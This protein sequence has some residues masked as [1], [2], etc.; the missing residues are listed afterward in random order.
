MIFFRHV[1]LK[2]NQLESYVFKSIDF[3]PAKLLIG[4]AKTTIR[5][6]GEDE[7]SACI[8]NF[9]IYDD[10]QNNGYG[11]DLLYNLEEYLIKKHDVHHIEF[12]SKTRQSE[13]NYPFFIKHN[14]HQTDN[15]L[16]YQFQDD[17]LDIYELY[18]YIKKFRF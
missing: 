16:N 9:N 17:G 18:H 8:H 5:K 15:V 4:N 10:Y 7:L 1:L 6:H 12:V 2:S 13:F 3:K 11:S 14:Y